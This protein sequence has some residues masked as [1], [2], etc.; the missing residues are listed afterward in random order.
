M[1]VPVSSWLVD[2]QGKR[3]FFTGKGERL[4]L[5]QALAWLLAVRLP[6][7]LAPSACWPCPA[8]TFL[9]KDTPPALKDLRK[10]EIKK[11]QVGLV[12]D[13]GGW[14]VGSMQSVRT[15]DVFR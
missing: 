9:P 6:A 14:G 5:A 8:G 1:E 15:C 3:A 2:G 7:A 11:M 10:D 12:C 4:L 13:N